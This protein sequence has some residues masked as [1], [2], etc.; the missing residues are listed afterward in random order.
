[1]GEQALARAAESSNTDAPAPILAAGNPLTSDDDIFVHYS[2]ITVEGF[3]VLAK[4]TAS[5]RD[6]PSITAPQAT[7]WLS[8]D[9]THRRPMRG[10]CH[11]R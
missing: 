7:V 3:I 6:R 9:S 10:A 5:L 2:G 1:M 8:S 11:S 4:T